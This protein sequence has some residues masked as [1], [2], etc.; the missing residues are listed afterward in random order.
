[1]LVPGRERFDR[2]SL[3]VKWGDTFFCVPPPAPLNSWSSRKMLRRAIA[4]FCAALDAKR[5]R[6]TSCGE[7]NQ[8][9]KDCR[10]GRRT[11]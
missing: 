7:R 3:A 2:P 9:R 5:R 10:K 6:N 11:A 8:V 1:M 4:A